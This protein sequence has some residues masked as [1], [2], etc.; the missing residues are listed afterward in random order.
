MSSCNSYARPRR[1][2]LSLSGAWLD[3]ARRA[4]GLAVGND[5]KKAWLAWLACLLV[6]GCQV[7]GC[8]ARIESPSE[9]P[10]R[11]GSAEAPDSEHRGAEARDADASGQ[12]PLVNRVWVRSEESSGAELPGVIQV[13]LSNGTMLSDSCW[14]THRLSEW[15][16]EPAGGLRWVEDGA[17]IRA[18]VVALSERELVLRLHLVSGD[19]DQRFVPAPVPYVCPDVPR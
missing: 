10:T 17:E 1:A 4:T 6:F 14:E 8:Q 2:A 16:R 15:S 3:G 11:A 9:S 7:L 18:D 12:D 19:E 5:V 13:F